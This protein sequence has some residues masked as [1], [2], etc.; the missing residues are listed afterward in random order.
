MM[1]SNII[2]NHKA[3]DNILYVVDRAT[4]M[5]EMAPSER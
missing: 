2:I 1:F 5:P 3:I 4:F